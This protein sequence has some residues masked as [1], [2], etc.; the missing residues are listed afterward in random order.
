MTNVAK[1][2]TV[3][4]PANLP[5]GAKS[6]RPRASKKP[7]SATQLPDGEPP[8]KLSTLAAEY[9][10]LSIAGGLVIGLLIGALFPRSAARRLARNAGKVATV[11]GEVGMAYAAQAIAR[12]GETA[13]DSREKIVDMGEIIGERSA[14]ARGQ[15]TRLI[16]DGADRARGATATLVRK[17]AEI[18][19]KARS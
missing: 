18:V 1:D 2:K 14:D 15:A 13:R 7:V 9:V 5:D 4:E 11:A 8:E 10:G 12:A 17:A 6:D 19:G 3:T 16:G